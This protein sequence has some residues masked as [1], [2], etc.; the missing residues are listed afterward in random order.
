MVD[1]ER[2]L[3]QSRL[4]TELGGMANELINSGTS[5]RDLEPATIAELAGD[6]L[7]E[8]GRRVSGIRVALDTT[9]ADDPLLRAT[10]E[11]GI[12]LVVGNKPSNRR[13]QQA[14]LPIPD[15]KRQVE[16][17]EHHGL[18]PGAGLLLGR[19]H[20]AFVGQIKGR[21]ETRGARVDQA[22][23]SITDAGLHVAL[24]GGPKM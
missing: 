16:V 20:G 12:S 13:G 9:T 10:T 6:I 17:R 24:R 19:V 15:E 8:R 5:F 22:G 18:P 11:S 7:A 1:S 21:L 14:E 2:A 3:E 4:T 23:L